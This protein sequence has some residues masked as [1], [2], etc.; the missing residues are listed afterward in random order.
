MSQLHTHWNGNPQPPGH[1]V[2]NSNPNY[3]NS[4]TRPHH[5]NYQNRFHTKIQQH[6][7]INLDRMDLSNSLFQYPLLSGE[8]ILIFMLISSIHSF[9]HE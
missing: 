2:S 3:S 6:S 8:L 1:H 7:L 9:I 4:K 5:L